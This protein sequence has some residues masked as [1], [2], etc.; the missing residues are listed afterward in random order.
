MTLNLTWHV[1][2]QVL[3]W[4]QLGDYYVC[5][6]VLNTSC[7]IIIVMI[8][9]QNGYFLVRQKLVASQWH[10]SKS[11]GASMFANYL[12][13]LRSATAVPVIQH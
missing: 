9:L 2:L 7:F 6:L 3:K 10:Q 5:I 13:A 4:V 12:S 8:V 11:V 1:V